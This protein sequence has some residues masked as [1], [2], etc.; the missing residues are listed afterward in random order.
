MA[1]NPITVVK[2]LVRMKLLQ[3]TELTDLVSERIYGEFPV[4]PNQRTVSYPIVVVDFF[5]GDRNISSTYQEANCHIYVFSR[6]SS[7]EAARIY[8]ICS[9]AIHQQS[10][11]QTGIAMGAYGQETA[12]TNEGWDVN[13]R[14]HLCWGRFK[15]RTG[16]I[17]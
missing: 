10:L 16:G 11:V 2:Q 6:K 8:D 3:T 9:D 12:R 15:I 13:S 1:R 17:Q 14:S 7:D 5:S 4:N